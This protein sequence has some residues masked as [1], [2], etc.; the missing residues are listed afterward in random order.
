MKRIIYTRADGGVTVVTPAYNSIRVGEAEV[1]F[2]T[3]VRSRAVPADAINVSICDAAS[4]PLD[5][6]FRDAWVHNAGVVDVDMSKAR[7]IHKD[8]IRK[9]RV[10]E[11]EK[12]DLALRDA[13]VNGDTVL[14]AKAKARR[15]ELRNA[16]QDPSIEAA[17]TPD[18]L[19]LAVPSGFIL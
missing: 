3:R 10:A 1:D 6:T 12:N 7:E 9:A 13:Q 16:P 5:R 2:L 4:V 18:E 15:D 11:F 8:K 17:A 14:L 19:V